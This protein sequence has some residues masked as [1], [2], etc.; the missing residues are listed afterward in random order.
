M[1][2]E[3]RYLKMLALKI[4]V[5]RPQPRSSGSHQSWEG[6]EAILPWRLG[7]EHSAADTWSSAHS[8]SSWTSGLLKCENNSWAL[9]PP[10][11]SNL[12]QQP[13]EA[14]PIPLLVSYAGCEVV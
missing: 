12:F 8:C 14:N 9:K 4:G 7:R 1:K 5:A 3:Q 6:H 2:T 13:Q 11:S 10:V